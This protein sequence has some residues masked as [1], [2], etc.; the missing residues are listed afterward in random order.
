MRENQNFIIQ[1]LSTY[2]VI[3]RGVFFFQLVSYHGD[4]TDITSSR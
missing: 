1:G 3:N 2:A 4:E